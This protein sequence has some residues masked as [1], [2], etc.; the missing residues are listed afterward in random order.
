M[1]EINQQS[2]LATILSYLKLYSSIGLDKLVSL[3]EKKSDRENIRYKS[4]TSLPSGPIWL[5]SLPYLLRSER[6]S[7]TFA[8]PSFTLLPFPILVIFA[9]LRV[10]WTV[11]GIVMWTEPGAFLLVP[12]ALPPLFPSFLHQRRT[13]LV[14]VGLLGDRSCSNKSLTWFFLDQY[15][16]VWHIKQLNKDGNQDWNQLKEI[17]NHQ[18]ILIS[19]WKMYVIPTLLTFLWDKVFNSFFNLCVIVYQRVFFVKVDLWCL[20]SS[21]EPQGSS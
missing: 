17:G 10:W 1:R 19:G 6:A 7:V 18:Q 14:G 12:L 4:K 2:A 5:C 8:W 13:S 9:S 3:L 16:C 15:C 21:A 11:L 20:A